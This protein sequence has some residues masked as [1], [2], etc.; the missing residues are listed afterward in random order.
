MLVFGIGA[1][2][3]RLHTGDDL[4]HARDSSSQVAGRASRS[5][6]KRALKAIDP[7]T[8]GARLRHHSALSSAAR[9][10]GRSAW[11]TQRIGRPSRPPCGTADL[12]K[13]DPPAAT[14]DRLER[15][16]RGPKGMRQGRGDPLPCSTARERRTR[17]RFPAGSWAARWKAL[18]P[19]AGQFAKPAT[20]RRRA[21]AL[22]RRRKCLTGKRL[23]RAGGGRIEPS[24][25]VFWG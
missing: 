24:A 12:A 6:G 25:G 1:F 10:R 17:L 16:E 11:K 7:D 19:E 23:K 5:A 14:G 8:F 4:F 13:L 3:K 20:A 2:A 9:S 15:G 22:Q 21:G 18:L